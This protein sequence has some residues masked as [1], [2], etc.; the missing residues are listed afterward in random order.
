VTALAEVETRPQHRTRPDGGR[1]A[2]V[3]LAGI[4]RPLEEF[5][6][7][8]ALTLINQNGAS[9]RE[10]LV[11]VR[12][13][14]AN[15]THQDVASVPTRRVPLILAQAWIEQLRRGRLA[16][17][18][19]RPDLR[20]EVAN[21]FSMKLGLADALELGLV[22]FTVIRLE[23]TQ[24]ISVIGANEDG[25]VLTES[26]TMFNAC[27]LLDAGRDDV[28]KATASY[29][30]LVW[31]TVDNFLAMTRTYDA[32]RLDAGLEGSFVCAYGLC[33]QTSAHMVETLGY[34]A[35]EHSG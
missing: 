27:V 3:L 29:D 25:S 34:T 6:P 8:L 23:S 7:V 33:L 35:A 1:G 14:A 17:A 12:N 30:P 5:A 32:A 16:D 2:A 24:G 22:R 20:S 26:L 18:A 9:T 31:G 10:I 15:K 21:M 11:G 13:P 4:E 19:A 28:P